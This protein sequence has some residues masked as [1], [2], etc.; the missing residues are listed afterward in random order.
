[1][2]DKDSA[3]SQ[4]AQAFQAVQATCDENYGN[5][6]IQEHGLTGVGIPPRR[7]KRPEDQSEVEWLADYFGTKIDDLRHG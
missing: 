5:K 2:P 6:V 1:M 4:R 3:Q 7:Q